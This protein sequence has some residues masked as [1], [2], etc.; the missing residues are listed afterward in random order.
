[1]KKITLT[2]TIITFVFIIFQFSKNTNKNILPKPIDTKI[3]ENDN[4][5]YLKRKEWIE[6]MHKTAPNTNWRAIDIATRIKKAKNISQKKKLRNTNLN[7]ANGDLIGNWRETG[8]NNL[9][10][11]TICVEYDATDDSIY[12]VS[13]GGN[14]WKASKT[15]SNWRCLNNNFKIPKI[16]MIKKI[17]NNGTNRLLVSSEDWGVPGFWY[18]DDDGETWNSSTGLSSIE[19]WGAVVRTVV[20]NNTTNTIYL[21]AFEWDYNAW[22]EMTSIYVSEDKGVSFTRKK[23]YLSSAYGYKNR[24]DIWCAQQDN[25][26]VYLIQNDSIFYFDSNFNPTFIS[27]TPVS[28]TGNLLLS[29]THVNNQ[30]Y[31]YIANYENDNTNFYKS[32]DSGLTWETKGSVAI[33]PFRRTSF[34]VSV[35]NPNILYYG[36][37]ECYV[38]NNAADS[39]SK[40][41]DWGDYYSDIVN[42]LHADIPSINSFIDSFGDEFEYINTDG[43]TYISYNN[44]QTVNNISTNNLNI[45]Q[46]YS[47]YSHR[48]DN[49]FIFAGSQDQGYQFCNNNDDLGTENFTQIVSGDYGHIVSSNGGNSIWMVYPGY[50]VYYPNAITSPTSSSWWTFT[51][52]GQ[53]WIPPLM[54][55]PNAPNKVY[56]GGGTTTSGTHLFHLTS[57]N[58]TISVNEESFDF[59]GS[60]NANAISAMAYS[61]INTDYR[62]V[63]NGEGDFFISTDGGNNWTETTGFDGPD[64]N[65]LYGAKI[66]PSQTELGKV[67]VAGSGYSNPPVYVSTDNGASFSALNTGLSNTMVYDMAITPDDEYLFAATEVGPYVYISANNQWYD[68]SEGLAPDQIY[69]A[70]DYLPLT[71]TVR[72]GTYGRGIWDFVIDDNA[73]SVYKISENKI[74]IYPN[75]ASNTLNI[76]NNTKEVS[77][78]DISGKLIIKTNKNKIDISD[79]K[80]GVYIVK[81]EKFIDKFVKM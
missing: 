45:S 67:Y 30:T 12:C 40:V 37:M 16:G 81:T 57:T 56:L 72:F 46:Y 44:L 42:K 11:R 68:L 7:I 79:W 4:E 62:Y 70:V 14:V 61:P 78:Y 5:D 50:A 25:S 15:G 49:Q 73:T 38:T 55:D 69:W 8:S 31:L 77:V 6:K 24:F 2:L 32:S 13:A 19:N 17:A 71:E 60:S 26:T 51:C 35:K 28:N 53:F 65:Y 43:G 34:S 36:G 22:E 80:S 29:G 21:L 18:S 27:N 10:G 41:N 59:S 3:L 66:V 58:G 74:F 1:M 75:P 23:T 64:G 47:V 48:T 33:N 9:A 63:M 76:K 20:A 52:T 54:E 39:W